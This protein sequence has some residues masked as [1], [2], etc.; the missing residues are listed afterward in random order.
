MS[1]FL[2][3]QVSCKLEAVVASPVFNYYY[4]NLNA[5]YMILKLVD[6]K[7]ILALFISKIIG[8]IHSFGASF[9]RIVKV[10]LFS[11]FITK[12]TP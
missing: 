4:S 1:V 10:L 7:L 9:P 8:Y 5:I 2:R 6:K 11:G 12:Q 3:L